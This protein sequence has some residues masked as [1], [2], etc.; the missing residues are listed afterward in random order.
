MPKLAG[1]TELK[2][3]IAEVLAGHRYVSPLVPKS[4][5]RLGMGAIHPL[6]GNLTPREHQIVLL[7]GEAKSETEIA[8]L[9]DLHLS[10][11]AFHKRNAMRKLGMGTDA[12][13][14][15]LAVLL[16]AGPPS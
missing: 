11:V 1:M 16:R 10:T 8:R 5:H 4:T 15:K 14:I 12:A 13:L 6:L 9:L 2:L 3:A 7:L